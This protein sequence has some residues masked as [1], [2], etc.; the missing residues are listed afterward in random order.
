MT[1]TSTEIIDKLTNGVTLIN[2]THEI[3][4][5]RTNSHTQEEN[6][7]S[8]HALSQIKDKNS[9]LFNDDDLSTDCS[10]KG[11]SPNP[12]KHKPHFDN[13]SLSQCSLQ[14]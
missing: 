8:Y 11:S 2:N 7:N 12:N 6:D 5:L 9:I 1:T 14:D 13:S 4:I 10:S 3:R